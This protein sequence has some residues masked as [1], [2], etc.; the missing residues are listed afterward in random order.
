MDCDAF[1]EQKLD[2]ELTYTIPSYKKNAA[3]Q[4]IKNMRKINSSVVS[5]PVGRTDLIPSN[6]EIKDKR[7]YSSAYFPGFRFS[8][9]KCTIN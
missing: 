9:R 7:V 6:Y 3:P 1:M 2:E 8:L 5:I 4:I